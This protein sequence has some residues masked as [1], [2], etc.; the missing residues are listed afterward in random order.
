MLTSNFHLLFINS[1]SGSIVC[2]QFG[3]RPGPTR[4]RAWSWSKL[5]DTDGI[6]KIFF[7][8]VIFLKKKSAF[9]K[10]HT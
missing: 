10:S 9:D 7:E 8:R 4:R 2:K 6:P 3:R 5:F 1:L